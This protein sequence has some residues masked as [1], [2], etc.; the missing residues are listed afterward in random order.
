MADNAWLIDGVIQFLR[1]P[2]WQMPVMGFID[3]KCLVF[4]PEETNNKTYKEIHTEYQQLVEFMLESFVKDIGIKSEEFIKACQGHSYQSNASIMT[5]FEQVEA[6]Q[7]FEVFK[8]M[9]IK[10]N[11]ELE[12]QVLHVMQA[13]TGEIPGI[14]QADQG[15]SAKY[16]QAANTEN[17]D[18]KILNEIL[19]KSKEEYDALKKQGK[20]KEAG[21]DLKMDKAIASSKE[22]AERLQREKAKEEE[23]LNKVLSES[24]DE[25]QRKVER[26]RTITDKAL[27]LS[28][29]NG[30]SKPASDASKGLP[31]VP[32]PSKQ[33]SSRPSSKASTT[34]S[35]SPAP[36][37]APTPVPAPTSKPVTGAEAAANWLSSAKAEAAADEGRGSR[38]SVSSSDAGELKKREEY[39]KKQRDLL[40]KMKRQERE[41][42]FNKETESETKATARPKSARAARQAT[43][44]D[45][46]PVASSEQQDKQMKMRLA[47]AARLKKEVIQGK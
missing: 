29:S 35:K 24:K 9:M 6:A 41:K 4:D 15:T 16:S 32:Q 36:S 11:I 39:L 26:E 30:S 47:L 46:K 8:R 37:P 5:L 28:I 3:Q 33:P 43:A 40:I 21:I 19:R 13:R 42:H 34:S 31:P 45:V 1:S 22:D 7:D 44:G 27:K 18:E 14:L 2:I 20:E 12:L 25:Y 38:A 10:Q 17:E 23:M